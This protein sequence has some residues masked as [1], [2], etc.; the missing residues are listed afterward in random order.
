M[1]PSCGA[2]CR[3]GTLLR[4]LV[5]ILPEERAEQSPAPTERTVQGFPYEGK[6]SPE[7]D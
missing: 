3:G 5:L 4:P 7:G 1:F 6:L 2:A